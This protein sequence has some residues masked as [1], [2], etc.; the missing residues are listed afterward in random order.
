MN[1]KIITVLVYCNYCKSTAIAVTCSG[2][3]VTATTA[4]TL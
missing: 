2:L 4:T 1:N 3:K